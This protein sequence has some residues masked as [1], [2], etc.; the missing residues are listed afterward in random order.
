MKILANYRREKKNAFAIEDVLRYTYRS[1]LF[2]LFAC[3]ERKIFGSPPR[4]RIGRAAAR[5]GRTRASIDTAR[6]QTLAVN[7]FDKNSR[8]FLRKRSVFGGRPPAQRF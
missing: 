5:H 4:K 8:Y 3:D 1:R 2:F 7:G 6:R